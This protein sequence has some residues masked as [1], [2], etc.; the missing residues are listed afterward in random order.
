MT[1]TSGIDGTA[2]SEPALPASTIARDRWPADGSPVVLV[3]G[4]GHRRQ[5]WGRLP[6]LLHA[7][8]H[9]VVAVDLPG[10]G[11]SPSP[12]RPDQWSLVSHAEQ[13]ERLFAEIGLD[14]P[15]VVGNSLGGLIALHLG[16]RGSVA[17]VTALSPAGFFSP[18]HL[19]LIAANLLYMK[20]GSHLPVALHRRL[21]ASERYRR[22]A[23]RALYT[24]P[25]K[26]SPDDAVGDTLGLR[27]AA[28]FWHHFVR[29]TRARFT[30]PVA[31]PTTIAWGDTD[32]LL[33]PSQSQV[34]RRRLPAAV[35]VTLADC[36]HCPQVDHPE[37]VADVVLGTLARAD[38]AP[39]TG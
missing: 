28:G 32:R 18:H 29:A 17:S 22:L 14:R 37:Q 4:I 5:A 19:P 31:V 23:Y 30:A 33:L 11:E 26:V 27:G 24:H 12:T 15:H 38:Q 6:D 7:A 35:H 1:A 9:D 20:G 34:A 25:E 10:H 36:G 8:G 39:L 3:H 21:N 16:A 13:L 2:G